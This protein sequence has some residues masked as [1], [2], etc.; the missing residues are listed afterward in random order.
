M[1]SP[2]LTIFG[3]QGA[4]IENKFVL[5]VLSQI[6]LR[7]SVLLLSTFKI[8]LTT[9]ESVLN[10]N[11]LNGIVDY[12]SLAHHLLLRARCLRICRAHNGAVF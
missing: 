5:K 4:S 12:S 9:F 3:I 6:T 2:N 8:N 7:F 10:F 11:S 1:I